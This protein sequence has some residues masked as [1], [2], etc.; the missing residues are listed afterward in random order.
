MG[1]KLMLDIDLNFWFLEFWL[2]QQGVSFE[3]VLCPFGG[4]FEKEQGKPHMLEDLDDG[5][6]SL[7]RRRGLIFCVWASP[8][9][10]PFGV[11]AW[12]SVLGSPLSVHSVVV[13]YLVFT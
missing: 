11:A 8:V 3:L 13:T 2:I 7:W 6:S 4:S 1:V 5:V 10:D 12:V 9:A